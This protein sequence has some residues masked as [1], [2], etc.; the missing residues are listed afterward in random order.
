M[1]EK[2][3][4]EEQQIRKN[5]FIRKI[6][7]G[8]FQH[9]KN[10]KA[11]FT[12]EQQEIL[13]DYNNNYTN[14][15]SLSN[16]TV[17]QLSN[18]LKNPTRSSN[19]KTIRKLSE[20]LY[21]VSS[22]YKI[23]V[24][25]YTNL[26]TYDHM[27]IPSASE[28]IY[29]EE[30]D[31]QDYKIAYA[32]F[33]DQVEKYNLKSSCKEIM[34]SAIVDGAFYGICFEN[35]NGFFIQRIDPDYAYVTSIANGVYNFSFDLDY[36]SGTRN[37]LLESYPKDIQSEYRAYKGGNGSSGDRTR[38]YYEPDD[39]ICILADGRDS[40][41]I[42]P[43]FTGLLKDI[44]DIEDYRL[45]KKAND[46]NSNFKAVT[47]EV[48]TDDD[49]IPLMSADL[50]DKYYQQACNNVPE[51][52]GVIMNPFKN[53]SLS[54]TNGRNADT[55]ELAEAESQFWFDSG[56]SPLLFGSSK[57]TTSGALGLSVKPNE[58]LAKSILEKI[59]AFFNQRLSS[60]NSSYSFKIKFNDT[61]SFNI[62]SV[63][64]RDFK[65]ST[66]GVAG[67]K[68]KYA[69][70]LGFTPSDIVGMSFLEDSVLNI[71]V[72]NFNRPLVSSNVQSGGSAIDD[73]EGGR[74][75]E[76]AED[77]TDEGEDTREKEKND[78]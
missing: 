25:Y 20:F 54:F 40:S 1:A 34:K 69:S 15:T 62:D 76:N 41:I 48:Q 30:F 73:S 77:L 33:A 29:N 75:E 5:E 63:C 51:G 59:E 26:L 28:K 21:E 12:K 53:G 68:L 27:L 38:R 45:I 7:N 72:D 23:L 61:S 67:A 52:V 17:S 56:T 37:Y 6:T 16:Y 42:L 57:A 39:G 18:M 11:W 19:Q 32:Q 58:R 4:T 74:P 55:T 35:D 44:F 49:G 65:A 8:S 14:S 10:G 46:E 71:T 13:N 31:P 2:K 47:L 22:H 66:Y 60:F 64:D 3:L 36:F 9:Y 78:S 50:L 43:L 70:D 24:N